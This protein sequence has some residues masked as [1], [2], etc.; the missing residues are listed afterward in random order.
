MIL[1]RPVCTE[2]IAPCEKTALITLTYFTV[3]GTNKT[4]KITFDH[5][6]FQSCLYKVK[7][8]VADVKR[9][10]HNP[11]LLNDRIFG[12]RSHLIF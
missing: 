11:K 8:I 7:S 3:I 12:C 10:W 1:T 9:A 5:L 6:F 2:L 4:T